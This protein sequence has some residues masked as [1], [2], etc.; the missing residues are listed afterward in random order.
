MQLSIE[1]L[2]EEVV[3]DIVRRCPSSSTNAEKASYITTMCYAGGGDIT[4]RLIT[5]YDD[6]EQAILNY[7]EAMP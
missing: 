7:L 2:L 4:C 3:Q 5:H 6:L 1:E